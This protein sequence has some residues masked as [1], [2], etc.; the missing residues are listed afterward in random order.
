MTQWVSDWVKKWLLER[1][2]PLKTL[3]TYLS[4]TLQFL[5]LFFNL[6]WCVAVHL[7]CKQSRLNAANSGLCQTFASHQTKTVSRQKLAK[8]KA[9]KT[10]L[11]ILKTARNLWTPK[12]CKENKIQCWNIEHTWNTF[13]IC[14]AAGCIITILNKKFS[15][16]CSMCTLIH[17]LYV[18]MIYL[19]VFYSIE[20]IA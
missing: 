15:L 10:N 11:W 8:G 5:Y 18:N 17:A 13:K 4:L 2:S 6:K 19:N 9:L 1:L 20:G 3:H 12:L 16:S 14:R 7:P